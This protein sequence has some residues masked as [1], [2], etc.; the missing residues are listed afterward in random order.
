MPLEN[1]FRI[2]VSNAGLT[3]IEVNHDGDQIYPALIFHDGKL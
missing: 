3:R 1:V 2:K